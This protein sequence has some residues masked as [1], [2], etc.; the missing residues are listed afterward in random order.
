MRGRGLD[1]SP[2]PRTLSRGARLT[3]GDEIPA[4]R[5]VRNSPPFEGPFVS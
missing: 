2:C 3:P 5:S 1:T 4:A